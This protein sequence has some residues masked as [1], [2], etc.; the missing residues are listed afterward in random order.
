MSCVGKMATFGKAP[1]HCTPPESGKSPNK[2]NRLSIPLHIVF[3]CL[4][5]L[6]DPVLSERHLGKVA[7]RL[8]DSEET[9]AGRS[10]KRQ[11][12]T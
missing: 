11:V 12:M 6:G 4:Q 9:L 5:D 3:G 10:S 8:E 2:L 7:A 1:I